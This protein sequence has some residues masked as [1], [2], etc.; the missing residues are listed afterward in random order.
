M[1]DAFAQQLHTTRPIFGSRAIEA[2]QVVSRS[3]AMDD[4]ELVAR[5]RDGDTVAF[6]R[7]FER[8]HAPV[9]NY[10]HRM[11]GD[12]ALAE[13]LT[14]DSFVKAYKALGNTR[15]DLAFKAWLYRIATNTAI[16]HLRRKKL[17]RWIPILP[18]QDFASKESVERS[19]GQ[20]HDVETALKQLP[21]HYAAVLILRHYEGLSLAETAGALGITENAA[22]LR[23]FRA[24]KAFAVAY[25]DPTDTFVDQTTTSVTG[26]EELR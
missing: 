8:Y 10:L 12:R 7:L 1:A 21:P 26:T 13:D 2:Q 18:T 14:Q 4:T 17:I 23:L 25:G 19:V 5:A 11:V 9:L 22:K 15:P 16:S 3:A 6:E 20:R 24:R